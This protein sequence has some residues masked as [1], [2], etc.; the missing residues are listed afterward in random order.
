MYRL[1]GGI[2]FLRRLG[3]A[4]ISNSYPM[5]DTTVPMGCEG[6]GVDDLGRERYVGLLV[7]NMSSI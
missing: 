6:E 4:T 1:R 5:R 3:P 7:A 2:G